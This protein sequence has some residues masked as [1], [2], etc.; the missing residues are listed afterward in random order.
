MTSSRPIIVFIIM[1]IIFRSLFAS[2]SAGAEFAKRLRLTSMAPKVRSKAKAQPQPSARA[3]AVAKT[4]A[5]A[6]GRARRLTRR[7]QFVVTANNHLTGRRCAIRSLN[8]LSNELDLNELHVHP[9]HIDRAAF[10]RALRVLN[11]RCVQVAQ[12]DKLLAAVLLW[13]NNRGTL[14][15]GV[16]LGPGRRCCAGGA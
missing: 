15:N 5:R 13:V 6:K 4:K 3:K 14:P 7:A 1:I 10:E 12:Q 11:R 9:K 8:A 2:C 16:R